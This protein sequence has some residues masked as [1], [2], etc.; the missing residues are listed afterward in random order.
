M[1]IL[2]EMSEGNIPKA[3]DYGIEEKQYYNI[4]DVMQD[5]GLIKD[6]RFPRGANKEIGAAFLENAKVTIRGMEY[7]NENSALIKTYKGLKEVREWLPF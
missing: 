7:L 2:K 5:D 4:L 6:V 3:G 1:S